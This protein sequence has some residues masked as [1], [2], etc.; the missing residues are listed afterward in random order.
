M[1]HT[2]EDFDFPSA[3]EQDEF[4]A[5]L[6]ASPEDFGFFDG[7]VSE[8][9]GPPA[10][11]QPHQPAEQYGQKKRS[12]QDSGYQSTRQLMGHLAKRSNNLPPHSLEAEQAVA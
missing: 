3:M 8:P 12:R 5:P 9:S 11:G 7:G 10:F 1:V 4:G 2:P 6:D